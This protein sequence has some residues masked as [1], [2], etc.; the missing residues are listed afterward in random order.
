MPGCEQRLY[1]RSC[2]GWGLP[3]EPCHH[4]SG[5]LLP[6]RF[7]LTLSW[8]GGLISVALSLRFPSVAVSDHPSSRSPDFPLHGRF[9]PCSDYM[10]IS[11]CGRLL[12]SLQENAS[13]GCV[14]CHKSY[15]RLLRAEAK[16]CT[17]TTT[18]IEIAFE[19]SCVYV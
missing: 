5:G 11:R 9:Q 7:T 17:Q 16:K 1:I 14:K 4:A 3:C 10:S 13:A 12:I 15:L 18:N 6:R 19:I 2:S 8:Q